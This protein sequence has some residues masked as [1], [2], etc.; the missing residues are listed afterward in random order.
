MSLVLRHA[1]EKAGLKMDA[2]GWVPVGDLLSGMRASGFNLSE[3]ELLFVIQTSDKKRFTIS[4]DGSRV[5]A[6]QGHSV[7]VDLGLERKRPPDQLL[8]GTAEKNIRSI[9][10]NGL[11]PQQRQHVHLSMDETTALKVGKRHGKPK[12]LKIDAKTMFEDGHSFWLSENEV[13][14]TDYVPAQYINS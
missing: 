14:L 6:A 7:E 9:F 8:H 11:L 12:I 4:E 2:G 3:D 10:E 1:P 5:R 13:W